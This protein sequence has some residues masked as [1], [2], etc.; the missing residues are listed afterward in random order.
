MYTSSEVNSRSQAN[1][2]VAA[3]RAAG[4]GVVD[5]KTCTDV[6]D[7]QTVAQNVANN[8]NAVYIPT[9]NL[10][11]KNMPTVKACI[12]AATSTT[13]CVVGEEGMLTSG[14]HI[15]Y[16]ISYSLLG[17]RT[18]EMAADIL[19]GRKQ[20]HEIDV[21]KMLDEK[22]LSKVYHS[23]NISDAGLVIDASVLEGFVDAYQP[24]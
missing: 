4:I 16:S 8:Y 11:A 15:T 6:S 19:S 20:T 24:E 9:D 7:L 23:K 21:E 22:Y 18:G 2:A 12:E 13:L 5:V 3:A 1:R 10:I 14:G 17:K